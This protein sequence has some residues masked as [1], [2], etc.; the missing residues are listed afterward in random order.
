MA[1]LKVNKDRME[2]LVIEDDPIIGRALQR[3]FVE[4]HHECNWVKEGT[5]GKE[6]AQSQ[7]FDAIILDLMLPGESGLNVLKD[8][9]E[10][11][12]RTPIII[13]TA[14]GSVDE[15][16]AGLKAGADDYVV[17]PFALMELMARLEAVCRRTVDRPPVE[18][19]VGLLTLD[20]A[21]RKVTC[22]DTELDLTPTEFSVLEMLMRYAGQVVTRKMLC[23][24]IW[25]SDWEGTTNVIEVHINRLRNKMQRANMD[26]MIQT[27]RGRGYVLRAS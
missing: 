13:L 18:I 24:H 25:E 8:L 27:V 15:R 22:R 10:A 11:G 14:L 4:A 19:R 7:K 2:I 20:L 26:D 17:K 23:E 1:P 12:V 5:R 9:R 3:G 16:V 6:L 21:T